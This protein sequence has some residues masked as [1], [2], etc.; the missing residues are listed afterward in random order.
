[1]IIRD[2]IKAT[3]LLLVLSIPQLAISANL[4]W[5]I[6]CSNGGKDFDYYKEVEK[7]KEGPIPKKKVATELNRQ[8][9]KVVI[10]ENSQC[11]YKPILYFGDESTISYF[12]KRAKSPNA[13][14]KPGYANDI[15]NS[16]TSRSKR[17][18][19]KELFMKMIDSF[20]NP[21][22]IEYFIEMH[23]QDLP[24][25]SRL[26]MMTYITKKRK[27]PGYHNYAIPDIMQ[28]LFKENPEAY[29]SFL[30]SLSDVPDE[31]TC[32]KDKTCP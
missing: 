10:N 26:D 30:K 32:F 1:M 18:N 9:T 29:D 6:D 25:Y 11:I 28:N 7:L 15:L 16:L 19:S 4:D 27:L 13:Y 24:F 14:D 17:F 21:T 2:I 22:A 3:A 5:L 31:F 12:R 8:L 23:L 20:K